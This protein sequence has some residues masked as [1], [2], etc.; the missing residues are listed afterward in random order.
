MINNSRFILTLDGASTVNG[1]II[2]VASN[3]PVTI[4][5]GT[6]NDTPTNPCIFDVYSIQD[7]H[8]P[9]N[10]NY[11]CSLDG[12][13]TNEDTSPAIDG[14][15][16]NVSLPD[17]PGDITFFSFRDEF[18]YLMGNGLAT[19]TNTTSTFVAATGGGT[20]V[21]AAHCHFEITD[22]SCD[23]FSFDGDNPNFFQDANGDNIENTGGITFDCSGT[24]INYRHDNF[25]ASLEGNCYNPTKSYLIF[26]PQT[27]VTG[28]QILGNGPLSVP[29]YISDVESQGGDFYLTPGCDA[30]NELYSALNDVV[31]NFHTSN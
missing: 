17:I 10:T 3:P 21:D 11:L 4:N 20:G 12:T 26:T 30:S 23:V 27:G 31:F 22:H 25:D 8:L 29:F 1:N 7:I 24:Y 13:G 16:N 18:L 28:L 6:L 2:S 5:L 9:D 15:G 14:Y 19:T